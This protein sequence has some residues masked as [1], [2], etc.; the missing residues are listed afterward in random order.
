MTDMYALEQTL[1]SNVEDEID[2]MQAYVASKQSSSSS[3]N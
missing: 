3:V 2:A 1:S